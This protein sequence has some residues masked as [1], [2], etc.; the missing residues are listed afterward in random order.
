MTWFG[1]VVAFGRLRIAGC[2]F[3]CTIVAS[4]VG[5]RWGVF[6][7]L[8]WGLFGL[9]YCLLICRLIALVGFGVV[10]CCGGFY[11]W[12]VLWL[13]CGWWVFV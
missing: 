4:F 3:G 10:T 12:V 2:C 8:V 7:C 13:G 9:G 1:F 6:L 5:S 11:R